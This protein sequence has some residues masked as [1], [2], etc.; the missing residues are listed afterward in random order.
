MGKPRGGRSELRFPLSRARHHYAYILPAQN[1]CQR[2]GVPRPRDFQPSLTQPDQSGHDIRE[3]RGAVNGKPDVSKR[4]AAAGI[5]MLLIPVVT[6]LAVIFGVVLW[7]A[8]GW[9]GIA[10]LGLLVWVAV[11]RARRRRI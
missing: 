10:A 2:S 9:Y 5:L 7:A 8:F 3:K 11:T 4:A 6:V 1:G